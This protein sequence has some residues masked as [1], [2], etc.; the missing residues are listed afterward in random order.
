MTNEYELDVFEGCTFL[1][2]TEETYKKALTA[3]KKARAEKGDSLGDDGGELTTNELL[4]YLGATEIGEVADFGV[5]VP[6]LSLNDVAAKLPNGEFRVNDLA[7]AI[8]RETGTTGNYLK[9]LVEAGTVACLGD[10]PSYNGWGKAPKL[11]IKA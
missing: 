2:I 9:K 4:A 1:T 11:Y 7:E 6:R 5:R 3:A 8:D 10:D